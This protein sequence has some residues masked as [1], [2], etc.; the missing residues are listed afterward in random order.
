MAAVAAAG[1]P[2]PGITAVPVVVTDDGGGLAAHV[3]AGLTAGGVAATVVGEVPHD[4]RGVIFLGGLRVVES[5]ADAVAVNLEAFRAARAVAGRFQA[6]GGVFVTV[7]DTGGDFGLAGATSPRAW[8]GGVAGL[9]HTAA[10]EWPCVSVKAIDCERGDRDGP[11]VAAALVRELL[12]G[13]ST[14]D[15]GLPAVGETRLTVEPVPDPGMPGTTALCEE[16]VIVV[17][18]GDP[19]MTAAAL[20]AL[21][22]GRPARLV[23]VGREPHAD[24]ADTHAALRDLTDAGMLVRYVTGDWRRPLALSRALA[25]IRREWGPITGV[26]HVPATSAC[27]FLSDLTEREYLRAFL[28]KVDLLRLLLAATV[29][30]PLDFL[31]VFASSAAESGRGAD[32]MADAVLCQVVSAEARRR[33]DRVVRAIGWGRW[34]G[35]LIGPALAEHLRRQD[36]PLLSVGAGAQAILGELKTPRGGSRVLVS[37]GASHGVDHR[38]TG[39]TPGAHTIGDDAA[40][41][42]AMAIEWLVRAVGLERGFA[43]VT[44]LRDFLAVRRPEADLQVRGRLACAGTGPRLDVELRAEDGTPHY[45]ASADLHAGETPAGQDTEQWRTDPV[46]VARGLRACLRWAGQVLGVAVRPVAVAEFRLLRTGA[47]PG[48]VRYVTSPRHVGDTHAECDVVCLD[49]DGRPRAELFGVR[50]TPR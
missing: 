41:P 37:A 49:E 17:S 36:I 24:P 32:A 47:A 50:L 46:V 7:Q 20:A 29:D 3:V 31:L 42:V 1:C 34:S 38:I 30:D 43:H 27:H 44:V 18:E 11:A 5:I 33:P 8:L 16:P 35:G 9:A 21:A 14:L 25:G 13:G 28:A 4:A 22:R 23:L 40:L 6:G 39:V 2:L 12:T 26:I 48:P 19:V 10:R 45:Q 15:V